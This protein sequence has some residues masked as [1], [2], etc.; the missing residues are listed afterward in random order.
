MEQ[1]SVQEVQKKIGNLRRLGEG[2]EPFEITYN[3][4]PILVC[5]PVADEYGPWTGLWKAVQA[6]LEDEKAKVPD[7]KAALARVRWFRRFKA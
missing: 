2:H 7:I 6:K 3:G 1:L 5:L 4:R